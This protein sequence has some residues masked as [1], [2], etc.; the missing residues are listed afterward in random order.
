MNDFQVGTDIVRRSLT[1]PMDDVICGKRYRKG[2]RRP[3]QVTFK[4]TR[5]RECASHHGLSC[6][7]RGI[8][9]VHIAKMDLA[10]I[11]DSRPTKQRI[12]FVKKCDLCPALG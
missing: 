1:I 3:A 6:R 4:E 7:K 9:R 12:V 5:K 10:F 11:C 8:A 2:S